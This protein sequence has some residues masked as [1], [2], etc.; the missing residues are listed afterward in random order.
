MPRPA[1]RRGAAAIAEH[2]SF[3][4]LSHEVEITAEDPRLRPSLE[5]LAVDAD[6]P[7]PVRWRQRYD[8]V[9][10]GPYEVRQDGDLA[11]TVA[12][13]DDVLYVVYA[14]CYGRARE[15]FLAAGWAALHGAVVRIGD[16]RVLLVGDKGV[17]KT[18][19]AL[20]LLFDG[21]PLEGDEAVLVRDGVAMPLARNLHVKP[22]SVDLVPELREGWDDLPSIGTDDGDRIR[23]VS[24]RRAGLGWEIQ[25]APV[26]LAVV[27]EA[28]HGEAPQHRPL[29]ALELVQHV[30]PH[31]A[32]ASES[33]GE[34]LRALTSVLGS[35]PGHHLSVGDLHR[36]A[37]T[38]RRLGA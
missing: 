11:D 34:L 25:A 6:Q 2:L 29:G 24:P 37:A 35:V 12:T 36:T 3:Q 22:G 38:V 8:V 5:Y 23:A 32:P 17:G 28:A 30:L 4:L 1:R 21:H 7:L 13:V 10:T 33:R 26:D 15:P 16:Q 31:A 9:G 27:L 18:T 20:R 19:L 14:R